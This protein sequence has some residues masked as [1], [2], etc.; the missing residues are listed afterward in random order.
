MNNTS[1][2]DTFYEFV[3][4]TTFI[5]ILI[6]LIAIAMSRVRRSVP[7]SHTLYLGAKMVNRYLCCIEPEPAT[8]GY[9][10]YIEDEIGGGTLDSAREPPVSQLTA[11]QN[12]QRPQQPPPPSTNGGI[13][14]THEWRHL[15]VAANN[16]FSALF[17]IILCFI[18]LF[19][20]L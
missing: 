9:Q 6:T 5:S 11:P 20:I 19:N 17:L 14:Y 2:I 12:I 13:D 10:R 3:V 4:F 16:L 8:L 15:Y 1:I 18:T 7:P